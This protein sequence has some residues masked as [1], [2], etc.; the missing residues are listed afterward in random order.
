[1]FGP[2]RF[3]LGVGSGEALNEHI[4]GDPWPSADIRLEML[5]EAVAMIRTLWSGDTSDHDGV[6]YHLENAR[7]YSCR[8]SCRRSTCPASGPRRSPSPRA[9]ATA[10]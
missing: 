8:T 2:G 7:I 5:E 4:L 3:G 6:Y 1:M 10:T 9:S